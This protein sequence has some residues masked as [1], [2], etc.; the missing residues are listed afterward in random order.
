MNGEEG[1]SGQARRTTKGEV[2]GQ[3]REGVLS[4]IGSIALKH[5]EG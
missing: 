4:T 5:S 1:V 3:G 2:E